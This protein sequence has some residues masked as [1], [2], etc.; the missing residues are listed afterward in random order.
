MFVLEPLPL[1][2]APPLKSPL[3]VAPSL[4]PPQLLEALLL[5]GLPL[6]SGM[7]TLPLF[8]HVEANVACNGIVLEPA[9]V[10]EPGGDI[11]FE[12]DG[13]G[14]GGIMFELNV[15]GG[16]GIVFELDGVRCGSIMFELDGVAVGGGMLLDGA[17]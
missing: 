3:L 15:V 2:L 16:G 13:V 9:L 12:V 10:F 1:L 5:A 4:E 7:R 11:V 14:G 8:V 6:F 17:S